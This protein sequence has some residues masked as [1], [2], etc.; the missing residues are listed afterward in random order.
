MDV[1]GGVAAIVSLRK[2]IEISAPPERVFQ[3]LQEVDRAPRWQPGLLEVDPSGAPGEGAHHVLHEGAA[4]H[5]RSAAFGGRFDMTAEA[6]QV[7]PPRRIAWR[8]VRGDLEHFDERYE[9]EA[10]PGGGTRVRFALDVE[11]PFRLPQF[12]T[13]EEVREA[14][15]RRY[16]RA[17]LNLKDL[18]EDRVGGPLGG[19]HRLFGPG[20]DRDA[21]LFEG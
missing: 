20:P 7:D 10:T 1:N 15:S 3:V 21:A 12:V 2:V 11:V 4:F 13:Q 8:Q 14:L 9:L 19:M 17:L 18:V 16:D 6:T 5:A